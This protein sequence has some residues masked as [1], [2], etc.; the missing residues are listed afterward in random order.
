[1]LRKKRMKVVL[2][3]Y[4][5]S[6]VCINLAHKDSIHTFLSNSYF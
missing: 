1:M 6:M 2:Y 5:D 3:I 4:S